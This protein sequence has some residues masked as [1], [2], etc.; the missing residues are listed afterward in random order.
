M[1]RGSKIPFSRSSNL[2]WLV[3]CPLLFWLL[4]NRLGILLDPGRFGR[5]GN[6][7]WFW[8]LLLLLLFPN[9]FPNLFW[10]WLLVLICVVM[11]FPNGSLSADPWGW[12]WA[13]LLNLLKKPKL[14]CWLL[15][16]LLLL[17][18]LLFLSK[19]P[20]KIPGWL[21]P[22]RSIPI[23]RY[24]WKLSINATQ[25]WKVVVLDQK[26]LRNRHYSHIQC[27]ASDHSQGFEDKNLGSSPGLLGQ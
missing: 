22:L 15:L 11:K 16:L 6:L 2:F 9:R 21:L 24:T 18:W 7:F 23:C 25:V 20:P 17:P 4:P 5:F 12:N 14:P 3:F 8:L 13:W 1:S 19:I 26:I 10:F 27:G